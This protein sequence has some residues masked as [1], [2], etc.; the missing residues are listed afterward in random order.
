MA[1]EQDSFLRELSEEMRRERYAKA[2]QQYGNYII[3]GVTAFVLSIAGYKIY[4]GRE[5]SAAQVAGSDF[6]KAVTL[7]EDKKADDARKA[8]EAIA[9]SGPAGYA[10]AAKLHLAGQAAK[11]GKTAE[12]LSIYEG[13]A[14]TAGND[15]LLT[16]YAQ[17]QAASL[18]LGDADFTEM[19]N[20]LTP[21]MSDS[22]PWRK[23]AAEILGIAAW[24]A[25]KTDEA[26]KLLEPL[27]ID[28]SVPQ[29]LNERVKI[30]MAMIAQSELGGTAPAASQSKP[31][32]SED[33]GVSGTVV[34]PAK[35]PDASGAAGKPAEAGKQ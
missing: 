17:L 25:G 14:N 34:E 8:F 16:S 10:A 26:R 15:S 31:A 29:T 13:L 6:E 27:L 18:R 28:P 7:Q 11:D 4:E 24:K 20:R 30:V 23:S 2:W 1:N 3:A 35:A 12:A 9:Q 5:I 32:V 22:S 21:L 33:S 19:Q